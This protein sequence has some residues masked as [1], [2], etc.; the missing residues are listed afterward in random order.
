MKMAKNIKES[1]QVIFKPYLFVKTTIK[2]L[3]FTGG[4]E[5]RLRRSSF[6]CYISTSSSKVSVDKGGCEGGVHA[7]CRT[8][9][10]NLGFVGC[11]F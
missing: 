6:S 8:V 11:N 9:G 7:G 3:I 5:T 2:V 1:S 10:T 4:S